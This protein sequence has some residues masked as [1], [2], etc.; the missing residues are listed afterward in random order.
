[1]SFSE[2]QFAGI[3]WMKIENALFQIGLLYYYLKIVN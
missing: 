1:M 2:E 3:K